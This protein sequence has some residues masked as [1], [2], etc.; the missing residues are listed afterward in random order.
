MISSSNS[1][2]RARN[3]SGG[4][5]ESI[6]REHHEAIRSDSHDEI[7]RGD[8]GHDRFHDGEQRGRHQHEIGGGGDKRE[9]V[10]RADRYETRE[11]RSVEHEMDLQLH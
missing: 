7:M 1:P 4:M 6:S 2:A 5:T 8:A 3:F 10:R 9:I 11:G